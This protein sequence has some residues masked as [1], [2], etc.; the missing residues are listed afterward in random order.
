MGST[1]YLDRYC[2]VQGCDRPSYPG[3]LCLQCAKQKHATQ[4]RA[5]VNCTAP[6]SSLKRVVDKVHH[7]MF[8]T[9]LSSSFFDTVMA[10]RGRKLLRDR[11]NSPGSIFRS[12]TY[13]SNRM[14]GNFHGEDII[15]I[16]LAFV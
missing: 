16:I 12:F 14:L 13:S 2:F 11:L 1:C 4:Q 9:R 10:E 15:D 6:D 8:S 5:L 3:D 7:V